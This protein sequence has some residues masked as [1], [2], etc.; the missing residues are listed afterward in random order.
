MGKKAEG[1]KINEL[2][3]LKKIEECLVRSL[4]A[5]N[6]KSAEKKQKSIFRI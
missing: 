6:P 5:V 2:R 3:K 1:L 4:K